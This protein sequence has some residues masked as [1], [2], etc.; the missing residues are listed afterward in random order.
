ME[1]QTILLDGNRFSTLSSFYEEVERVLT[2]NLEWS[3]GRN[4]DAFNDVLRGGFGVYGYEEPILLV[5]RH[6]EKSR[7]DLGWDETVSRSLEMAGRQEG[8][9][10]FER[11]VGIIQ[12]HAHV[13]LRLE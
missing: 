10:L 12:E 5:W 11:I 4:L 8:Q 9:T 7:T 13:E 3:I 1:R 2:K 6:S